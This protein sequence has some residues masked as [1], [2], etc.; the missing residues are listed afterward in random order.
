MRLQISKAKGKGVRYEWHLIDVKALPKRVYV[1]SGQE[2]SQF[3]GLAE[4]AGG[5]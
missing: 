1:N 2:L 3:L 5:S 4:V